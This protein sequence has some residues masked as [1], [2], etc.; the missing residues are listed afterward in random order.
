MGRNEFDR[1]GETGATTETHSE[2]PKDARQNAHASDAT[3]GPHQSM[4]DHGAD[5]GHD[6]HGHADEAV[7]PI[8]VQ[9]WAAGI[10]GLAI[11]LAIV[12]VMA[13]AAGAL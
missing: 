11:G 8:N 1:P 10:G 9:A 13:R 6:D 4:A 3:A 2:P 5:H 7:G 12:V